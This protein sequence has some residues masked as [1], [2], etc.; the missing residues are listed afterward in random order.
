MQSIPDP[1]GC[2]GQPHSHVAML[3]A[4]VCATLCNF[5]GYS[6]VALWIRL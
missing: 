6:G 1:R 2:E 3:A 4:M 5:S